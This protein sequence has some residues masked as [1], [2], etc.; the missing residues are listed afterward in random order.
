MLAICYGVVCGVAAV[1][2]VRRYVTGCQWN[3]F[4]TGFTLA[5][6]VI[7]AASFGPALL[8]ALLLWVAA[9][10]LDRPMRNGSRLAPLL[11][12]FFGATFAALLVVTIAYLS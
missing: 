7:G 9:L 8:P 10:V 11:A 6:T 5:A 1:A 3:W 2:H 12:A 4:A